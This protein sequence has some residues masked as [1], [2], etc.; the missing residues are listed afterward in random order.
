LNPHSAYFAQLG[1]MKVPTKPVLSIL[2]VTVITVASVEDP[3]VTEV[4]F[5]M[6]SK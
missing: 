6:S 4:V 2:E 1:P 3:D 5:V